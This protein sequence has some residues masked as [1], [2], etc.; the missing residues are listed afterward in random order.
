[1]KRLIW[2]LLLVALLAWP[3]RPAAA[4][5]NV[6]RQGTENP[7]IE[8][9][10]STMYGA[11]AGLVVGSA[12]ALAADDDNGEPVRWGTVIGTFAGLGGGIYFV[13][14]RPQPDALLEIEEGSPRLNPLGAVTISP[15]GGFEVRALVVRF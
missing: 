9:A 7:V 10:K 8:I 11:L 13:S 2:L 3:A 14:H 6:E 15:R 12:I 1:M 5:V 4:A